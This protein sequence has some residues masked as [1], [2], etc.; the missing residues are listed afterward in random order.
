MRKLPLEARINEERCHRLLERL[1][2]GGFSDEVEEVVRE[3]A[4]GFLNCVEVTRE[5]RRLLTYLLAMQSREHRWLKTKARAR[6]FR[7]PDRH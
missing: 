4:E 7:C 3:C 6:R 5:R 2:A 1:R